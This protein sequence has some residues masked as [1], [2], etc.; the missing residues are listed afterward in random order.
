MALRK[1]GKVHIN[2]SNV[3]IVQNFLNYYCYFS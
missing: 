2:V 3:R 1:K